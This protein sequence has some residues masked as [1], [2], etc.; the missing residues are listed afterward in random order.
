MSGITVTD[1]LAGAFNGVLV[2]PG[3]AGYDEV[4][5]VHNGLVD[6][7]PGLIA[8]CHNVADVRDAVGACLGEYPAG[9]LRQLPGG[10][11]CG[12]ELSCHCGAAFPH[13]MHVPSLYG[14]PQR[15]GF[16]AGLP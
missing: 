14:P 3:D 8:R 15:Q 16:S 5:K 9:R 4:R 2:G 1:E 12:K 6:K 7:R 11:V 13:L 10:F